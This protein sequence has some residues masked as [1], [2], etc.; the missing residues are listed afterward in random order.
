MA[1]ALA[2]S[3]MPEL[4]QL[5]D[6]HWDVIVVPARGGSLQRCD[7]DGKPVL[8][9]T[10][11]L[12]GNGPAP[13]ACCYFP[14]IPFSNRIE[15]GEFHFGGSHVRLRSNVAGSPH[16]IH[17]HGWQA[18]WHARSRS[19]TAC[20]LVF[21]HAAGSGWPWRYEGS[22]AFAIAGDTLCITLGIRNLGDTAM[23]CGL[24]FHPFFPIRPDARLQLSAARVWNGSARDFP[25]EP[26][27]VPRPLCFDA[28]PRVA[29][30]TGLDHCYDGWQ[31][32]AIL[33]YAEPRHD[34]VVAASDAASFVVIYIPERADHFCVEPVTHAINAMNQRDPAA[35]GLWTL[36]P[37]EN[38]EIAM[39]ISRQ[40]VPAQ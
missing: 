18:A 5:R 10:A 15:N 19:A 37:G 30:R 12:P 28:G 32:R 17:G 23:P 36:L 6:E 16:V 20:S 34:L 35:A 33:S 39:T 7:F 22:Q 25:R 38:R 40:H 13:A 1:R 9:S 3:D 21:R 29:E 2:T 11:P 26:I 24:G 4:I 27:V 31:G 14:L 8:Q